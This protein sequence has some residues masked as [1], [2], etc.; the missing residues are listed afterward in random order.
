MVI[1]DLLLLAW[2]AL[3][4]FLPGLTVL[5]ALRRFG[6][7]T[8]VAGAPPV[9]IGLLYLA[10]LVTGA[11]GL[12]FGVGAAAGVW[13]VALVPAAVFGRRG[14]AGPL[15]PPLRV[16]AARIV[17]LGAT[18]VAVVLALTTWLRGLG[19]LSTVPQEHDTILHSELVA[20]IMRT[21][22]AAPWQSFPADLMTGHPQSFYPNGFHLYAAVVGTFAGT[23]V[24]AL[25]AAMLLLFGGA[26]PLG[27]A[28]LGLR[29]R[30][31]PFA[32]VAGG[33]AALVAAVSYRPL[34]ALMHDGGVLSNAAAFALAPAVVALLLTSARLG[35]AGIAPIALAV[36]AAVVVHPTSIATVGWTA[37]TW[38]VVDALVRADRW[39][40]LGRQ[41]A[42]LAAGAVVA[43]LALVPFLV[44]AQTQAARV[45]DEPRDLP[46]QGLARAVRLAV[47]APYGGYADPS[48]AT[49]QRWIFVL[50]LIGVALC[51]VLRVNAAMVA[52]LLVWTALVVGFLAGV[53]LAPVR[54]TA[55][56]YYNSY[57]RL[58]GG[59]AIAQWLACGMAVAGL[60]AG[61]VPAVRLVGR[62]DPW[63]WLGPVTAGAVLLAL[64]VPFLGYANVDQSLVARRYR[65][66]EFT[67]VDGNDLAAA[68]YVAHR[69][70]PGDRVM[71]N[72]NDGSTYGYVY[73]GLPI[74]EVATIG[75]PGADS[76]YTYDLLTGFDRLGRDPAITALVC[77][78]HIG[79]V[80]A[81][82]EAPMIGAPPSLFPGGRFTLAPG[83]AH[84]DTTPHVTRAAQFGDVSVYRVDRAALGCPG[85][86]AALP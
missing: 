82:A 26:L 27:V 49:S 6:I 8:V 75:V 74:V 23:P 18:A 33:G 2:A 50:S 48:F 68:R 61:L 83:L 25:N 34:A 9:T 31:R 56:L 14:A 60:A 36:C 62:R 35:L 54:I 79:W 5:A 70:A 37:G 32:A 67:R 1:G 80:I 86:S 22:R 16:T 38:V 29:L 73:Y 55:N 85:G 15:L 63:P 41:A 64:L 11:S 51:L 76:A 69:I 43:V 58:I 13:L 46:V 81:D 72:A 12:R 39:R 19:S 10:A 47:T 3:C 84:L 44:V 30:P 24:R 57:A 65:T 4:L 53:Q 45:A 17:G 42:T 66:P 52:N 77:T 71:N 20:L 59:L 21:G 7:A 78:L 28:A 40:L